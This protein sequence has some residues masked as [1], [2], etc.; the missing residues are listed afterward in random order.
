MAIKPTQNFVLIQFT[1]RGGETTILIPD[2]QR[3]PDS[4][5][6]VLAVGPEVP[7]DAMIEAGTKVL[8]RGDT[9]IYGFDDKKQ[10]ACVLLTAIMAIVEDDD[11]ATFTDDQIREL[12]KG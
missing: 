10:Q 8:L 3:R 4:D 9:Q 12:A 6:T 11:A 5:I 7:K 2:G 1:P